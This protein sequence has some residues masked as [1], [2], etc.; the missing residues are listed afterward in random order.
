MASFPPATVKF[1]LEVPVDELTDLFAK[2]Q[3]CL[4]KG[5]K[6]ISAPSVEYAFAVPE[7]KK[8]GKKKSRPVSDAL[9]ETEEVET[10]QPKK[11]IRESQEDDF[12]SPKKSKKS[13]S[14]GDSEKKPSKSKSSQAKKSTADA[15][16]KKKTRRRS[17][18]P[19]W[20]PY[21]EDN[22]KHWKVIQELYPST[23]KK[24]LNVRLREDI[25]RTDG[26]KRLKYFDPE[27]KKEK[28]R[29]AFGH[30]FYCGP[31][32]PEDFKSLQKYLACARC[33]YVMKDRILDQTNGRKKNVAQKYKPCLNA[34]REYSGIVEEKYQESDPEEAQEP[35]ED[36]QEV[37]EETQE[38][39]QEAEEEEEEEVQEEEVPLKKTSK[40]KTREVTVNKFLDTVSED[41]GG[42]SDEEYDEEENTEDRAFIADSQEHGTEEP[43]LALHNQLLM[44]DLE[45]QESD[46]EGQEVGSEGES[47][48]SFDDQSS[49]SSLVDG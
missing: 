35:E 36:V 49:D 22:M 38:D 15:D 40:S 27:T 12:E 44:K 11:K 6:I 42:S 1:T 33:E 21:R 41:E 18:I 32:S 7:E 48:D 13:K 5:T 23:Y 31:K 30:T 26:G 34:P 2:I 9:D 19:E 8:K 47:V 4:P 25:N 46:N 10:I 39:A 43:P 45:G 37:E 28:P 29:S 24:L 14:S 16:T 3:A 17:T 20:C